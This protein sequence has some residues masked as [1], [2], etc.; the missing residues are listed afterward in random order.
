MTNRRVGEEA[1]VT[2]GGAAQHADAREH[3]L[4]VGARFKFEVPL[5]GRHE[6]NFFNKN[7]KIRR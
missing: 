7:F 5:F 2:R 1:D 6:F 4:G 3:A